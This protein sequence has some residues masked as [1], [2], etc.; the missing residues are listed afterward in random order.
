[1]EIILKQDITNLGYKDDIVKVKNGY[2]NNFLIPKGL[3]VM[4][5]PQNKKVHAENMKQ[6]AVKLEKQAKEAEQLAQM[7]GNIT[8]KVGAKAATT[9][10]IFGS[11][12]NIQLAD[13][14]K[15]QFNYD[16][17]RKKIV[18]DSEKIKELGTYTAKVNLF[19][20]IS[21]TVTFEVVAE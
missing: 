8:V 9:G 16:V 17:D 7:L 19:K 18:I 13:A 1:M 3:A 11:V 14:I 20:N 21:A 4:A 10:K 15:A 5:T 2:A 6:K 12:N